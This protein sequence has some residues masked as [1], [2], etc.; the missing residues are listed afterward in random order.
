[1]VFVFGHL[2]NK[3][4]GQG[5]EWLIRE[6]IQLD[7]RNVTNSIYSYVTEWTERLKLEYDLE[8][9]MGQHDDQIDFQYTSHGRLGALNT[10]SFALG[11]VVYEFD[12]GWFNIVLTLFHLNITRSSSPN[13]YY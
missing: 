7:S 1:M 3:S 11:T 8:W 9:D 4:V 2:L 5:Y 12:F 13:P 6:W 10:S